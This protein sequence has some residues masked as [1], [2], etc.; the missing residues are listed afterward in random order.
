MFVYSSSVCVCV[1]LI[2]FLFRLLTPLLLLKTPTLHSVK[3]V[4]CFWQTSVFRQPR[5]C[6]SAPLKTKLLLAK[7]TPVRLL[8]LS[9]NAVHVAARLISLPAV[10]IRCCWAAE[11]QRW[12]AEKACTCWQNICTCVCST[13]CPVRLLALAHSPYLWQTIRGCC[14]LSTAQSRTPSRAGY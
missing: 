3:A 11:L 9:Q 10:H 6:S 5:C 8:A 2:G 1:F 7:Q 14:S 13:A 12:E 4:A